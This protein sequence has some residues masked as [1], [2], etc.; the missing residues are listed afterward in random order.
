[1]AKEHLTIDGETID[2]LELV[3]GKEV[4]VKEKNFNNKWR[5]EKRKK[6]RNRRR[7]KAA[8]KARRKR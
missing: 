2:L 6:R 4:P 1:L 8:R 5:R 3:T 7:S